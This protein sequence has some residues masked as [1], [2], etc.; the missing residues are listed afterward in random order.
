MQLVC[1]S[2]AREAAASGRE[3]KGSRRKD[4]GAGKARGSSM[5]QPRIAGSSRAAESGRKQYR[6]QSSFWAL[7]NKF[8][9]IKKTPKLW[10]I[11]KHGAKRFVPGYQSRGGT[12]SP[13]PGIE[14]GSFA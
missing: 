8:G 11:E 7:L 4:Q 5:Q 9:L 12:S 14:P 10:R 13:P 6:K 2:N 3:Q 1:V